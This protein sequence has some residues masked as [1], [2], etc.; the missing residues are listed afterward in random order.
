MATISWHSWVNCW[1]IVTNSL[2][3][4]FNSLRALWISWSSSISKAIILLR[5]FLACLA[6]N[7]E[8]SPSAFNAN[9]IT[10]LVFVR[11]F[12]SFLRAA[13]MIPSSAI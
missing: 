12:F 3:S 11:I 7:F 9:A 13:I 10:L 2:S 4:Y 6:F 5:S 1:K 8:I